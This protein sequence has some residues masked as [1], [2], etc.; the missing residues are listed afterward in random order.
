MQAIYVVVGQGKSSARRIESLVQ[1]QMLRGGFPLL[2]D[3]DSR[4]HNFG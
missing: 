4:H 3:T 2:S 1:Q